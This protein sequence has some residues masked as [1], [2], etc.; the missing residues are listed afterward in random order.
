MLMSSTNGKRSR[1]SRRIAL[2]AF[3]KRVVSID[4]SRSEPARWIRGRSP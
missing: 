1:T 2:F 4:S 3:E